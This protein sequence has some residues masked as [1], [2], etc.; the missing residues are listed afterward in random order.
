MLAVLKSDSSQ[1]NALS[2]PIPEISIVNTLYGY[3]RED[4]KNTIFVN[5]EIRPLGPSNFDEMYCG[6][7]SDSDIIISPNN[8]TGYDSDRGMSYTY[9]P[10]DTGKTYVSGFAFLRTPFAGPSQFGVTSHRIMRKNNYVNPNF[11]EYTFTTPQQVIEALHGGL[12][13]A[14]QPMVNPVLN[15]ITQY[16]FTGDPVT[17]VGWLDDFGIDVRNLISSGPFSVLAGQSEKISV[18]WVIEFGNDLSEAI[19]AVKN[20]VDAIRSEPGC[21]IFDRDAVSSF[22]TSFTIRRLPDCDNLKPDATEHP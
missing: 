17:G 7:Y 6:F 11:G 21:G 14:G 8:K 3:L 13:N 4:L 15:E 9:V 5:Y 2:Q 18:V 1:A 10:S 22:R 20:K 19:Q 16:A 12:D